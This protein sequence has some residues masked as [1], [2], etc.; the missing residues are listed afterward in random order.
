MQLFM[1]TAIEIG[2]SETLELW[3]CTRQRSQRRDELIEALKV[4]NVKK[5]SL[6][7]YQFLTVQCGC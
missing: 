6:Q 4:W 2:K 1:V 5:W 7:C 3:T